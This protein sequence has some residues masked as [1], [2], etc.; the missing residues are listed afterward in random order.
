MSG[1]ISFTFTGRKQ[2]MDVLVPYLLREREVSGL[3]KHIWYV[4]TNNQPDI[5]HALSL[6]KKYPGFFEVVDDGYRPQP[7]VDMFF[8]KA[9]KHFTQPGQI[10]IKVD[11]DV[12]FIE[13]GAFGKLAKFKQDNPKYLMVLANTVN[14]GLCSHIHQRIGVLKTKDNFGWKGDNNFYVITQGKEPL[15]STCAIHE[16]F[17]NAWKENRLSQYRFGPF[18]VWEKHFWVSINCFAI[19]GDDLRL[20]G[21]QLE[22]LKPPDTDEVVLSA[23]STELLGKQNIFCGDALV[24]H[25]SFYGQR[26]LFDQRPAI[27]EAYKEICKKETGCVGL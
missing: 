21:N 23:Q 14:N 5:D 24:S 26:H 7:G 3:A 19:L 13:K 20:I 8:H 10:Y 15:Q 11:D 25:F 2:Y 18:L 12:C 27:W 6:T 17:I 9:Y 4:H 22:N 1:P 16:S